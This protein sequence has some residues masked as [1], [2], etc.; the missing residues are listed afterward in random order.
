MP[1]WSLP[2]SCLASR[3]ARTSGT[4]AE[5]GGA[6]SDRD[7]SVDVWLNGKLQEDSFAG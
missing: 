5:D 4:R 6:V 2:G 1:P 7:V 3:E